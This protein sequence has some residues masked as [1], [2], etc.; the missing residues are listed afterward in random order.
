MVETGVA[1]GAVAVPFRATLLQG[2]VLQRADFHALAAGDA[3]I[4]A[5]ER[6]VGD[7]LVEAL[8]DDVGLEP[9]EDAA[10]HL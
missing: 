4:C 8:P 10:P 3:G 2:D 6:L 1:V 7:P 5:E 9:R